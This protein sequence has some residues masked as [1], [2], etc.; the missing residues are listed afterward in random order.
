MRFDSLDDVAVLE[1][2]LHRRLHVHAVRLVERRVV[3]T[4][5]AADQVGR[6][7]GQRARLL[8]FH[9]VGAKCRQRHAR[10]PALVHDSGD[11]GAHAAQIRFQAE[12]SGDVLEDVAVSVDEPG[13]HQLAG[14]VDAFLCARG[15]DRRLN[16]GDATVLYRHVM[17]AVDVLG[18]IDDPAATQD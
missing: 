14:D 16:R 11:A 7:K 9:D 2:A 17:D 6:Q 10:G 1:R 13:Q 18:R 8:G 12:A 3:V 4:F 15:G 5:H